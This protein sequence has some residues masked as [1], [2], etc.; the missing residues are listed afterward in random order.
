MESQL[1]RFC[2][3][4]QLSVSCRPTTFTTPALTES[5]TPL[6]RSFADVKMKCC[7]NVVSKTSQTSRLLFLVLRVLSHVHCGQHVS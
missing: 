3:D 1:A 5:T 7:R 2:I 4:Y 6:G